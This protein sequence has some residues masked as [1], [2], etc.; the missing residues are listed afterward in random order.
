MKCS[1]AVGVISALLCLTNTMAADTRPAV[2]A[3][4]AAR[5]FDGKS[6]TLIS[7]GVVV[8]EGNVITAAGSN[9]AIPDNAQ[10]IDLG[11]ATLSPGFMDAHSHAVGALGSPNLRE[12]RALL[13]Q[14]LTLVIGNPDGGGPVDLRA[15]MESLTAAGPLVPIPRPQTSRR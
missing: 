12:A 3:L 8:I 4:K 9:V 11:D 2:I 6:K 10:I 7:N 15:Q 5:L 13:A 14:G 1:F